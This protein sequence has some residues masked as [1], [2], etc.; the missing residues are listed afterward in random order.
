MS[1]IKG[2]EIIG[3]KRIEQVTEMLFP[4]SGTGQTGALAR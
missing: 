3:L 1:A 4:W 2:I